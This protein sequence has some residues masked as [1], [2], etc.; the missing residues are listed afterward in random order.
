VEHVDAVLQR[1]HEARLDGWN[2]YAGF[3]VSR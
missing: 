1:E 2:G 3:Q